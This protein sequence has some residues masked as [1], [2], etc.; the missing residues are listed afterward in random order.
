MVPIF[1]QGLA[2]A[3]SVVAGVL[4]ETLPGSM[5]HGSA[6]GEAMDRLICH[7]SKARFDI[8]RLR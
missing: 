2:R 6:E 8:V 4:E 5:I 7:R 1:R 3:K